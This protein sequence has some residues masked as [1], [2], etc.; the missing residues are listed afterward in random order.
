MPGD[1]MQRLVTPNIFRIGR[2]YKKLN[3]HVVVAIPR[4]FGL[5]GLFYAWRSGARFISAFH[6]D[7]EQLARICWNAFSRTI[8]NSYLRTANRILCRKSQTVLIN[9]SKLQTRRGATRRTQRR[10]NGHTSNPRFW[11]NHSKRPRKGF[12]ALFCRSSCRREKRRPHH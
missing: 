4:P 2:A 12:N 1:P 5:L 3:P 11:K 8:V 6:T 10:G 7:F 9:N